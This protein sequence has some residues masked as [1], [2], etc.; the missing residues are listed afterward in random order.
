MPGQ[1]YDA[2]ME[3]R[4]SDDPE[5]C[6]LGQALY[7]CGYLIELDGFYC[8]R[9]ISSG[10]HEILRARILRSEIPTTYDPGDT[11]HPECQLFRKV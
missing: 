8:G 4:Q 2:T 3:P 7:R 9:T 1:P 6:G 10:M 11:P 5:A